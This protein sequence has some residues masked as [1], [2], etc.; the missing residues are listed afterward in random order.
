MH[1][2]QAGVALLEVMV[3]VT[4]ITVGMGTCLR[5]IVQCANAQK[6]IEERTFARHVAEQKIAELRLSGASF[7]PGESEGRFQAP[8]EAYSWIA[9]FEP[10]ENEQPFSVVNLEIWKKDK[11]EERQV[12]SVQTLL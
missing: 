3:S 10:A 9:H 8:F 2:K 7:P 12:L 5:V 1:R 11:G 6:H 4:I